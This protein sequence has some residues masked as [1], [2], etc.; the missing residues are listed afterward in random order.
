MPQL[1]ATVSIVG[2]G[3]RAKTCKVHC[4]TVTRQHIALRFPARQHIGLLSRYLGQQNLHCRRLDCQ[5][6]PAGAPGTALRRHHA[7]AGAADVTQSAPIQQADRHDIRTA[8]PAAPLPARDQSRCCGMGSLPRQGWKLREA[9]E[10]DW[11]GSLHP[12][13]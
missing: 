7:D 4:S 10:Q 11:N 2:N 6:V 12:A 5:P 13:L 9:L 3:D 8:R 1:A